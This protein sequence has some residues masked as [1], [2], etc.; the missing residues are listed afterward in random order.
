MFKIAYINSIG[1]FGKFFF[2]FSTSNEKSTSQNL[3][4]IL[5]PLTIIKILLIVIIFYL[6]G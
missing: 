2:S 3:E 6:I 4:H 5:V 1:T